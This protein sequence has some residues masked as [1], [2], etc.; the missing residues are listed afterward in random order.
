MRLVFKHGKI[1]GNIFYFSEI[2]KKFEKENPQIKILDEILPSA[3]DSQHQFYIINLEGKT[4]NLDVIALDVIWVPE[5]SH[6]GWIRDLSHLIPEEEREI[7]FPCT[8]EANTY[9]GRLYAIPWYIDTGVLY[10][11]KDLLDRYGYLP[12]KT[13][14]E[15]IQISQYILKKEK[16]ENL[17]GFI[18]Q[19]K[20]YEGLICNALEYIWGN[21]G[22]IIKENNALINS[23]ENIKALKFM[24]DLIYK[25]KVSPSLVTNCDE[26]A[27]RHI[28][29]N[30][31]AIFMRN[32]PYAWN[33]FQEEGSKV[34]GKIG[35]S[36]LPSFKN[37]KS[38]STLGGWQLA[39]NKYSRYPEESERFIKYM[40]SPETQKFMAIN[41]GYK[42]TRMILYQDEELKRKQPFIAGLFDILKNS[43]PRPVTPYYMMISQVLQSEI[44]SVI[45]GIKSPE[46]A[47]N[48]C[49]K[50]INFILGKV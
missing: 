40:I 27:T 21:N 14:E 13:W 12:P 19:G 41:V 47:L 1:V 46:E 43:K 9:K 49:E 36:P 31:N 15:L 2:I 44:S 7:F 45:S 34:R 4:S 10:Y 32:W 8:V 26:E 38:S 35:I 18:W 24:R 5:F 3:T 16:D 20:Q 28:F 22:E 6:A 29:G 42:P 23:K 30:G 39:I 33:L 11:R 50:Q 25:Y 17:K 48:Y 37:G